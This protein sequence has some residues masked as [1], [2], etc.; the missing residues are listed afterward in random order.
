MRKKIDETMGVER[1]GSDVL[2]EQ[3]RP[4][5]EKM[6]IVQSFSGI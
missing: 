5:L 2:F 3:M 1:N 6:K 4:T